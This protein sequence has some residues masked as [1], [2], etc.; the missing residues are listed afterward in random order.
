MDLVAEV[1]GLQVFLHVLGHQVAPVGGG[2]DQQVLGGGGDRSVERHLERDVPR[3]AGL[4]RQV[5]AKQHEALG[6][7]GD[8]VDDRR[9]VDQ[10]VLLDLD[11]AQPA[12]QVLV[13]QALHDR[14]F[15]GAAR[16]GQ[17]HVVRRPAL[18][19]L[20]RVLLDLADL[21]VDSLQVR[22]FHAVHVPHRLKPAAR[23]RQP[24]GLAPAKGDVRLPVDGRRGRQQLLLEA[25]EHAVQA[26]EQLVGVGVHQERYS[27]LILT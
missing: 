9:Q 16:A 6:A 4:E 1:P 19:E 10:I 21:R 22:E 8:L 11:Q 13:E 3:L 7:F 27:A 5:V 24:A 14:G 2:V 26:L 23:A 25:L 18:D 20:A 12:A 17:Q 15:S